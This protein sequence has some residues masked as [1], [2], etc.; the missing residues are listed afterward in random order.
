MQCWLVSST[1][2]AA[3][4]LDEWGSG[5]QLMGTQ[6]GSW[7]QVFCWES[8]LSMSQLWTSLSVHGE[9]L[10]HKWCVPFSLGI[11]GQLGPLHYAFSLPLHLHNSQLLRKEI[12]SILVISQSLYLLPQSPANFTSMKL[13]SQGFSH[14]NEHGTH[15]GTSWNDCSGSGSLEQGR[16]SVWL[17]SSQVVPAMLVSGYHCEQWGLDWEAALTS[18]IWFT[19]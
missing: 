11:R 10:G 7:G 6:G 15:W 8:S 5:A 19:A 2:L 3:P 17:T 9:D 12:A 14:F 16:G 4:T 13:L 1:S 18:C